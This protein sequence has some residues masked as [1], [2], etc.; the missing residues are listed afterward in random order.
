MHLTKIEE[1]MLAGKMGPAVELA[2]ETIVQMGKGL[3]AEHLIAT[4]G[5]HLGNVDLLRRL[6]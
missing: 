5:S 3:N 4:E 1:E 6:L 2:M